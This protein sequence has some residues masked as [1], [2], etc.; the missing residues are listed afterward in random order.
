MAKFIQILSGTRN[1]FPGYGLRNITASEYCRGNGHTILIVRNNF[2]GVSLTH[3]NVSLTY[4]YAKGF[5]TNKCIIHTVVSIM[6]TNDS[7]THTDNSI[8][9][10]NAKITNTKI[11][12][13]YTN[14]SLTSLKCSSGCKNY[15][16]Y[17]WNT[18]NISM[19]YY[20]E[21][22][23]QKHIYINYTN[24]FLFNYFFIK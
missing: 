14:V 12:I 8:T 2:S 1:S 24:R 17:C 20:P 5:H 21:F 22:I 6:N 4:T 9:Y 23:I 10:T 11:G 13:T 19:N 7:I 3:T 16:N 18:D 15:K